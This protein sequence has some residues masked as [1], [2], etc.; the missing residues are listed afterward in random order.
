MKTYKTI[1]RLEPAGLLD[2]TDARVMRHAGASVRKVQPIG[3]P[4]NGTM[5]QCY[6]ARADTGEFIGLVNLASLVR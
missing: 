2:R 4:K 5:R 3:C 1:Y 6:V